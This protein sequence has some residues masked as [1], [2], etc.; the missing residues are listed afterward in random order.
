L[1][2]IVGAVESRIEEVKPAHVENQREKHHQQAQK[3]RQCQQ[4][5]H[6]GFL[7]VTARFYVVIRHH[8]HRDVVEKRKQNDVNGRNGL[9]VA[10]DENRQQGHNLC[11][12]R[13]SER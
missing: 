5:R 10:E 12:R 9:V 3:H 6:R 8:D 2:I 4:P 11:H 1:A 7:G 13:E